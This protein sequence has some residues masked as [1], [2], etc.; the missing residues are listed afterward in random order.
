MFV[1]HVERPHKN[2]LNLHTA[3]RPFHIQPSIKEVLLLPLLSSFLPVSPTTP[4]VYFLVGRRRELVEFRVD[5]TNCL[6]NTGFG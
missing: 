4:L 1:G 3:S 5:G 2:F 6:L